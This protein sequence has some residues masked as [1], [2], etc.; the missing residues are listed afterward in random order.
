MFNSLVNKIYKLQ[1]TY[2]VN[3]RIPAKMMKI[4]IGMTCLSTRKKPYLFFILKTKVRAKKG[5]PSLPRISKKRTGKKFRLDYQYIRTWLA[6][7]K[8]ILEK[9]LVVC[10]WA[11]ILKVNK[12]V[13]PWR[14]SFM[15]WI[16][17]ET[18][19]LLI[20]I[21]VLYLCKIMSLN[22]K[23]FTE[24]LTDFCII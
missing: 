21:W 18:F 24:T 22:S 10:W 5:N 12:I 15:K 1:W 17:N 7:I 3:V 20:M 2:F 13:K 11:K 19:R 8:G 23:K 16:K 14:V 4:V 9:T 6:S